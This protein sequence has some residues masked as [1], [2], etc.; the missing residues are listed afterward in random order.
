MNST[1]STLKIK[2]LKKI[3]RSIQQNRSITRRQI[4]NE[5]GLSWGAVS[6]FCNVLL[7]TGIATEGPVLNGSVGKAPVEIRLNPDDF[8]LAGLDVTLNYAKGVLTTLSGEEL[9]AQT[10]PVRHPEQILDYL[11]YILEYFLNGRASQKRVLAIGIS[12][13]GATDGSILRTSIF[14]DKWKNLEIRQP[15]EARFHIPVNVYADTV[16][17]L[18][19]E[20]YF[21]IM[22]QS[23]YSNVALVSLNYGVGMAWMND[24]HTYY[25][26]GRHQCELG[27]ITVRPGGTLCSCG[28]RGCL[29]M[30]ASPLGITTQFRE[31]AA[32]GE[33]SD[34]VLHPSDG[35]LYQSIRLHARQGDALSRRL[36]AQAGELL[37]DH[38]ASACSLLEP[39]LL[40]MGGN[41]LAD[42]FLWQ[43]QFEEHFHK[44][45]FP[46]CE[47]KISYS[48]L[49][50]S[51]SMLGA[52]FTALD[53]LLNGFLADAL[54]QFNTGR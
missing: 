46:F 38:C 16:C 40:I 49:T 22:R 42:R 45:K 37:G 39:E 29:E 30:Y 17:V 10:L 15:L 19:A 11:E 5:T 36:F 12:V 7:A 51:A 53:A 21:G 27:H 6:Q 43:E 20:K 31:A 34:V 4:Q 1:I 26:P 32:R 41:L 47:T 48:E 23:T 14:S 24:R 50:S 35:A 9:D 33:P 18:A 8:L 13:P 52:A 2:N 54:L 28:K 44:N 25:S 3:F